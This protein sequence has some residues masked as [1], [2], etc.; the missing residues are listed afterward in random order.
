MF[1]ESIGLLNAYKLPYARHYNP[2]FVY[3]LPTFGVHFFVFKEFFFRKF[4]PYVWL[5]FK[6]G[7]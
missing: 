7:L 5:V 2:W 3:F 6:S 1:E 4:C